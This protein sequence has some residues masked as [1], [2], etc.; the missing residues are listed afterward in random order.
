MKQKNR[1]YD[2][3]DIADFVFGYEVRSEWFASQSSIVDSGLRIDLE[4]C[5]SLAR[6]E[7]WRLFGVAASP[8]LLLLTF[9]QCAE[10]MEIVLPWQ[11]PALLTLIV[12]ALSSCLFL[13][14]KE[15]FIPRSYIAKHSGSYCV[16]DI[17]GW[18]EEFPPIRDFVR[19]NRL[20]ESCSQFEYEL[21]NEY[22]WIK[23]QKV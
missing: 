7:S 14:A 21:V 20:L 10:L 8:V 6:A 9:L 19:E 23:K 2:L 4:A 22:I 13:R 18:V 11:V 3:L 1:S 5:L 12:G 17:R 16:K 15:M